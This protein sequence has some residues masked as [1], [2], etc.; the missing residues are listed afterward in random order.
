M[1]IYFRNCENE[2]EKFWVSLVIFFF[3]DDVLVDFEFVYVSFVWFVVGVC[4]SIVMCRIVF[5]L[6]WVYYIDVV[7][8]GLM[9]YFIVVFGC[10]G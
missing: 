7:V 2:E 10:L 6:S 5:G 8:S 4:C 9:L 1:V 3:R